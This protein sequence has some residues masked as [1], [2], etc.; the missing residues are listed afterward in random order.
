MGASAEPLLKDDGQPYKAAVL[1]PTINNAE[2]AF[3]FKLLLISKT[4]KNSL[5]IFEQSSYQI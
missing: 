2:F 5:T 3:E 4:P 1:I